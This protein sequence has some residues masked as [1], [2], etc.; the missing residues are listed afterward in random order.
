MVI[1]DIKK[2]TNKNSTFPIG[3]NGLFFIFASIEMLL[4]FRQFLIGLLH[5]TLQTLLQLNIYVGI[6]FE[7]H[8]SLLW[9]FHFLTYS[10]LRHNSSIFGFLY[11]FFGKK[12]TVMVEE[13]FFEV[14]TFSFFKIYS[15]ICNFVLNLI[16]L[17]KLID[18][19]S[20]KFL[21]YLLTPDYVS[22][23][24]HLRSSYS[25]IQY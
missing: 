9:V 16:K 25:K 15:L 3:E 7:R 6:V 23:A 20:L 8:P 18:Y 11:D 17:K 14:D 19:A 12:G 10:S 2:E 13:V 22:V 1:S 24:A 4:H 5:L 21:S